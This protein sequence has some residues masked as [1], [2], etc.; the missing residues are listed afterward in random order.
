MYIDL[1][2]VNNKFRISLKKPKAML[3]AFGFLF[4]Y[5]S[6][7][8]QINYVLNPS[9]EQVDSCPVYQ[10]YIRAINWDTLVNG[11]GYNPDV[12]TPCY[13]SPSGSIYLGTPLNLNGDSYQQP[14]SGRNYHNFLLYKPTTNKIADYL[15]GK[16]Y[17]PLQKKI[18]V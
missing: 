17:K 8:A 6:N 9:F 12:M 5:F 7:I 1:L 18:I 4:I 14:H 16:F 15:Q 11:G 2:L 3:L 13:A 10:Y